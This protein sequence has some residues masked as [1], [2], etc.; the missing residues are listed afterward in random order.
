NTVIFEYYDNTS[1]KDIFLTELPINFSLTIDSYEYGTGICKG[2]F[3][4]YANT[5]DSSLAEIK[6]GTFEIQF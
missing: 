4:G 3:S 6:S 5:K 2:H 1:P